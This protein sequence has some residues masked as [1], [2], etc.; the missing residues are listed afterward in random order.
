MSPSLTVPSLLSSHLSLTSSSKFAFINVAGNT[1]T[2]SISANN[3]AN[4]LSLDGAG[5]IGTTNEQTL[6]LGSASTGDI[7]FVLGAGNQLRVNGTLGQTVSGAAQ[8][9]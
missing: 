7:N 1:P 6:T 4:A 8:C 9:V 5:N 3:G 2:A